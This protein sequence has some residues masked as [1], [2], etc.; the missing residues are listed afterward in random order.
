MY[1]PCRPGTTRDTVSGPKMPSKS[2]EKPVRKS[3]SGVAL[4]V[5]KFGG[6]SLADAAAYRHAA[7]IVKGRGRSCVVVVSAPAGVTDVLLGLA[8]RAAAGEANIEDL[9][10]DA[11]ALR[12]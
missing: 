3:K 12:T 9:E 1:R 10:R 8:K 4:E 2:P 11:E 7:Q 5:H 6:A